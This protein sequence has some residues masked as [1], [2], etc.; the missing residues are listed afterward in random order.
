MDGQIEN[1]SENDTREW[2][3]ECNQVHICTTK[4]LHADAYHAHDVPTHLHTNSVAEKTIYP[5]ACV[6]DS[7]RLTMEAYAFIDPNM[8]M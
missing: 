7:C 2:N 8:S 4:H 5:R 1:E 6:C 3:Y